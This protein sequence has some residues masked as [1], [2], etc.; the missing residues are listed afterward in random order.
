MTQNFSAARQAMIDGQLRPNGIVDPGILQGFTATPREAFVP[1]EFRGAA[2]VDETI[3]FPKGGFLP[4]PLVLARLLQ[5]AG[6]RPDDT[7]LVIGDST[8]YTAAFLAGL[9][10]RVTLVGDAGIAET[11][12]RLGI[13][14]VEI[15]APQGVTGHYS[16]VV[17]PG[18]VSDIPASWLDRLAATGRL[19][20]IV[21]PP[22]RTST[23][24]MVEK[25]SGG[26]FGH[27]FL[28]DAELPYLPGYAPQPAFQF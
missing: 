6:L 9:V 21:R 15:V 1:A 13:G 3:V 20:T 5:F 12:G 10:A 26:A 19:L 18:A 22:G 17:V 24:V 16:L 27:R 28:F 4:E 7:V 25:D 8:G 2:Y 11:L 14:N 23:L